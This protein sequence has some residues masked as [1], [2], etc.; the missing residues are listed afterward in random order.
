MILYVH[1]N[2]PHRW[3]LMDRHGNISDSGSS[4][5]LEL[6][7]LPKRVSQTV[8]VVPGD[9]VTVHQV[10]TPA[11]TRSKM[12][13]TVPY[14]LEERLAA[15]VG[16]IVFTLLDWKAGECA[17]VSVAEKV[18]IDAVQDKLRA[19][20]QSIDA[21]V[22]EYL[23]LPLHPQARYTLARSTAGSYVLR[24]G[25][26]SGAVLD[27]AT[28]T[29]WWESV[30]D[31]YVPIAVND[32]ETAR[33]LIELGGSAISEWNI[34][35]DFTEWLAHGHTPVEQ[36]NVLQGVN[37]GD[38]KPGST[39]FYRAAAAVFCVGLLA[40][41]GLDLYDNYRLYHQD[42]II[43]KEIVEVFQQVFPDVKRIVNP[44]LQMEQRIR[45]L[46]SGTLEAG[47][48]Q[49][50]MASVAAAVPQANA[51]L[52]EVA[53]GDNT[54]TIT[55]TTKDFAGLDQLKRKF[56]ENKQIRAEL[57][58]SGSRDN[59]VSARFELQRA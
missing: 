9:L 57:I 44:R 22:P 18:Y 31:R 19:L 7:P 21:L 36:I 58:S 24:T 33:R 25:I 23:L 3:V 45:E 5:T 51:T 14:A 40:K 56:G 11:R 39:G 15:D 32:K 1:V 26:H 41:L 42:K 50:L 43:D 30:D 4:E 55:C 13:A 10:E 8:G 48:F 59:R 17:T 35:G 28:L 37:A 53:Y 52:E 34:G 46:K 38:G 16:D 47:Q 49:L 12:L 20:P 54:M 29:F 2:A 27:A 6:V